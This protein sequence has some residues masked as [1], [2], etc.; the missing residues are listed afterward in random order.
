MKKTLTLLFIIAG[1]FFVQSAAETLIPD[2][3]NLPATWDEIK[4]YTLKNNPQLSVAEKSLETARLSYYQSLT[5]FLP[6]ISLSAGKNLSENSSGETTNKFSYGISGNLSL[7]N[8][9]QDLS[10]CRIKYLEMK[11]AEENYRRVLSDVIFNVRKSFLNLLTAQENVLLTQKILNRRQENSELIKLKYE[12]GREDKGSYLRVEADKIQAE[13]EHNQA[14]RQLKTC[15]R[16]LGQDMGLETYEIIVVTGTLAITEIP[17]EQKITALLTDIPEMRIADYNYKKAE[18]AIT[19]NA[20][21]FYPEINLSANKS[22]TGSELPLSDSSWNYG[23][24]LSY[25][26]FSGGKDFFALKIA[27]MNQKI[28]NENKKSIRQQLLANLESAQNNLISALENVWVRQTY[29]LAAEEQSRIN[30][31]KYINGLLSY[32]DWYTLENDLIT[33]KKSLLEAQKNAGL[34]LASWKNILGA[35]E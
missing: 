10:A 16:Q 8:G 13:Y 7:F 35:G 5:G 20:G 3:L 27:E 33:A 21:N 17:T 11:I 29:L 4:R 14:R 15:S 6:Q 2:Q 34:A 25:P 9:W 23:L 22:W 24:N 18:I 19:Q 32:Q 28:S 31:V 12:A 1:L 26:I 30:T